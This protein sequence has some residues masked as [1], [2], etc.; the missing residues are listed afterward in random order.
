M[1]FRR[2]AP[3]AIIAAVVVVIAAVTFASNRLFA[4]LTAS[5]EDGQFRLMQSIVETALRNAADNALG[6]AEIIAALPAA[7]ESVASKNRDRLLAEYALMFARQKERHGVDQAQFHVLPAVSLLRLQDPATYGDD[8][9]RFRP[10]VVAVNREKA[11][12]KGLAIARNGP[13]VFGVAPIQDMQGTHVGSFEFGLEFG[14]LLD[15][16][17]AAYGLDFALFVEEKP[18]REFARGLNPA[19]LSDQNRVGH[20]IRFHTT[21]GALVK[22]LVAD[23]DLS[24]VAEST[25]YVRD[26]LG[27]PYG[28][29]LVPVRDGAGD[30]LGVIMAASDF[31]GS[32]AASGRAL[33]WQLCIAVFAIVILAGL[34]IVVIRGFLLRPLDVLDGRAAALAK[35]ER[36]AMIEPTDMFCAEIDRLAGHLDRIGKQGA[37]SKS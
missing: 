17:K 23:A 22:A 12:R 14:A 8:L 33:V 21:N 2:S 15:G 9:T 36:K 16:L 18:L 7:R 13:A 5:V 11:A 28:T 19:V 31:S 3:A 29:L 25:R 4:G 37:E 32:R 10:I 24:N 34:A 30:P 27:L 1:T 20:F 6:R 26:A 35:G